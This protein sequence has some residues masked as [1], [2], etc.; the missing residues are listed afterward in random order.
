MVNEFQMLQDL[1]N[2]RSKLHMSKCQ[3][4]KILNKLG[5]NYFNYNRE[6]AFIMF[7]LA[8]AYGNKDAFSNAL[9]YTIEKNL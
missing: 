1:Q 3:Y 8:A 9:C 2:Y 4:S 5:I 7:S 6:E